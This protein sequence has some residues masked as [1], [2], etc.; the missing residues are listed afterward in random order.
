MFVLSLL[1]VFIFSV[2]VVLF[3]SNV[4]LVSLLKDYKFMFPV[5]VLQ[6]NLYILK[7]LPLDQENHILAHQVRTVLQCC[8]SISSMRHLQ[9]Q[10]VLLLL[11]LVCVNL[12]VVVFL[13]D[14]LEGGIAGR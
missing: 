10:S 6:V 13:L 4:V 12:L 8:L 7:L 14:H 3:V 2:L 11:M 9:V 5:G 1:I